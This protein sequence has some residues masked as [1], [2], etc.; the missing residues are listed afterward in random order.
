MRPE[1]SRILVVVCAVLACSRAD[2]GSSQIET[3]RA[4]QPPVAMDDASWRDST[5]AMDTTRRSQS[6]E[7]L[8]REYAARSDSFGFAAGGP[9]SNDEWLTAVT[10]CPGHQGGSDMMPIV[11]GR[12]IDSLDV[13]PDTARFTIASETIGYLEP[14]E[15]GG[16]NFAP[17]RRDRLDTVVV[18]RTPFGWRLS[19][20]VGLLGMRPESAAEVFQLGAD[21]RA[22]LDSAKSAP[23]APPP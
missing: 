7:A 19:G 13:G 18:I 16:L 17:L 1:A 6:P 12:R 20:Q 11:I 3:A 2:D 23:L 21:Q 4:L 10:E 22:R 9:Q 5:C 8:V 15:A 14:A